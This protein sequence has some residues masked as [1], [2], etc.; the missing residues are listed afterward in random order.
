[1]REFGIPFSKG[2]LKGLRPFTTPHSGEEQLVECYN[3]IPSEFSLKGFEP[4]LPVGQTNPG[5][6][7][8][9][10]KDQSD[11][12]WYWFS[13]RNLDLVFF[14]ALPTIIDFGFV[15]TDLTPVIIPYWLQVDATDSLATQIYI[16]PSDIDGTPFVDIVPPAIGTGYDIGTGL[17]FK[18]LSGWKQRLSALSTLDMYWKRIGV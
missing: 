9:R 2:L 8:L 10:I 12:I 13:G 3:L 16:Y 18:A 1:M 5:L 17:T 15:G 14:N 11:V 7:Y 6:E 4:L